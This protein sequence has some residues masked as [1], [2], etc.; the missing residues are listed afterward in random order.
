MLDL[1]DLLMIESTDSLST[2]LPF[3]KATTR[4]GTSAVV[5][6]VIS[7]DYDGALFASLFAADQ[8]ITLKGVSLSSLHATLG[9]A[10]V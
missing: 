10:L 5:G 7:V 3:G 9:S 2:Y 1:R 6:I 8:K 4:R